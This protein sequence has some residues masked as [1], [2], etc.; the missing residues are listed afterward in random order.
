MAAG[1]STTTVSHALNDRGRVDTDTRLRVRQVAVQL[2]YV[3]SRSARSLRTRRSYTLGLSLPHIAGA[4]MREV[5]ASDWYGQVI[6]AT[7]QQA[8][9]RHYALAILPELADSTDLA[10]IAVDGVLVLDP[11]LDDPR[12]ELL[13]RE[14]VPHVI[15]GPYPLRP[16]I[17]RVEP[18]LAAGMRLLLA[19]LHEQE[20]KRILL[21]P[22]AVAWPEYNLKLE[23][24]SAWAAEH[25]VALDVRT[26]G[27]PTD[28]RE[29]LMGAVMETVQDTLATGPAPDAII[30]LFEGFGAA[31]V[32]GATAAGLAVPDDV[33]VAQDVDG[34]S[35]RMTLPAITALDLHPELLARLGVD[36]LVDVVSGAE[37]ASPPPIPVTLRV[38]GSSLPS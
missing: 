8:M 14:A 1:V 29:R 5:L 16:G 25:G 6:V 20:A 31:A 22:A 21:L 23:T 13:E 2:G 30:G 32:A 28:D 17:P 34:W 37:R 15:V 27:Q 35:A 33:R 3:P 38:R 12:L 9:D 11:I 19:H 4:P 36:L 7:S 26:V 24:A 10:R 18:D